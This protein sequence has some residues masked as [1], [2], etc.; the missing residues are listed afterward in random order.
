MS[1]QK[2]AFHKLSREVRADRRRQAFKL[3]DTG[4][5]K[6]EVADFTGV[7]LS[8]LYDW[9]A[10]KKRLEKDDFY[11]KRRGNP[12][13][14]RLLDTKKQDD[15]LEAI[16]TST[17]NEHGINYHL[18]SA[19]AIVQYTKK[20][21]KITLTPKRV[22]RYTVRW[23]LSSQRPKKQ[24]AEQD[25]EKVRAWL[26]E[27]Y[28]AIK[29]RAKKE[30]AEI[31][32]ADETNLNINTNYQKAYGEKGST[33]IVKI[34]ARKTGMSL[35]SSVTNQ[36]TFRYMT[37]KGGMNAVL[38]R[39]FLNRL[40]KDTDKKIFLILDNLRV[41]HAKIMQKWE[42]ENSDRIELFFPAT[43]LPPRES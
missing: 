43:I 24:A 19:R 23:N 20:K 21:H 41:H 10:D 18:W 17:P 1:K 12:T 9:I 27:T 14:R 6:Q 30:G 22:S 26:E 2:T 40:I 34:P 25:P 42:S 32:W 36:G 38:F 31:H 16:L 13:D 28:P 4:A 5:N 37:Y 39:V 33:P 7:H 8:V 29:E 15:I 3:L 11:G 35:V